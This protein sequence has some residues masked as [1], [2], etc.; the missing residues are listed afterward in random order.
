MPASPTRSR[1]TQHLWNLVS[2]LA[3]VVDDWGMAFGEFA[4]LPSN[5]VD[6][7]RDFIGQSP[8]VAPESG[9]CRRGQRLRR[10]ARC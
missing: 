7:F 10:S 1:L 3:V 8:R 4:G 2:S 6:V 9:Q 5:Q